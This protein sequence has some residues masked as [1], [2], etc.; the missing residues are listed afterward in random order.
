M[1]RAMGAGALLLRF[2]QPG[3][4]FPFAN[5]RP[6]TESQKA[7]DSLMRNSETRMLTAT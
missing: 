3:Q 5:E 4:P 1:G 7:V 6:L 2:S